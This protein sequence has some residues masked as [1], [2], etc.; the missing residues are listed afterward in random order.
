MREHR[1]KSKRNYHIRIAWKLLFVGIGIG[2]LFLA[3]FYSRKNTMTYQY[4]EDYVMMKEIPSMLGFYYYT[5]EEWAEKLAEEDFGEVLTWKAVNWILE[6]TGSTS[7]ITYKAGNE[8]QTVSRA[9]WNDIYDQILDLLD[10]ENQ[11]QI[12]DEVVLKQ[13]EESLTCGSGTYRCLIE[14]EVIRPMT[15]LQF[16]INGDE[17]VGIRKL[18]SEAASVQNVF[19]LEADQKNIEFLS[20]GENY[21]LT[22]D[23]EDPGQVVNHVCDLLWE[24]GIITKVRIKEDTIQ[25]NLIAVNDDSIEIEGYGEIH[26][27]VNLPVYKT[28]GTIEQKDLSDIVIANMKVEYVVAEDRVEAIM[29]VEPAQISRIRVMLLNDDAAPYRSEVYIGGNT[30][31]QIVIKDQSA[32][33][34]AETVVKASELFTG[35]EENSIQI[36]PGDENG[37]L[38]L[39]DESGNRLSRGYQGIFELHRY[40]EGFTV[41]NELLLEQYL[42]SVVPSE[43]PVSYEP[44]ALKAQA[45]CARSYAYIQLAKGDYAAFGAH[46]DDSTNYQVYNK[47]DRDEKTTAAV[48][49]TAGMVISYSGNTAEAYYFSTSAG[50]T[51]NGDCW[52]LTENP[53]YAY[54][55]STQVKEG[56][57]AIDLSGEEAFRQFIT[58]PDASSYEASLPYFRW[59]ATGNYASQEVQGRILEIVRTRKEKTPQDICCLDHTQKSVEEIKDFGSLIKLSITKRST[60]GVILQIQMDYENGTI[61]AGNEYTIRMILGAGLKDLTL[62]DGTA[63]EGVTVLPSAYCMLTPLENGDYSITGGGYGHGIGM[64]QNGAD[65]MASCGKSCEEILKFF[66]QNVEIINIS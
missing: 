1:L 60:S 37:E 4:C 30:P 66:F 57:G 34:P 63:K 49:D 2:C 5:S 50:V 43:M 33:Q 36:K 7:Y 58:E 20:S 9:Q 21:S 18:Q 19:I 41:V 26:R 59:K 61:L 22:L 42:C 29:L 53:S 52:N 46:V 11:V 13:E 6:Q 39:C 45:I 12:V 23:M 8:K 65:I 31:Y 40:A 15:A 54:L 32:D 47:Q 64:S 48:L 3:L 25:G 17:I 51:G 62:S 38:F 44:E 35:T 10:N 14:D 16:Y 55:T 56:G 28:Y 27:S 24:N